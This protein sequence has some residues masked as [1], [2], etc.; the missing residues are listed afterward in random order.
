MTAVK[1]SEAAHVSAVIPGRLSVVGVAMVSPADGTMSEASS[2]SAACLAERACWRAFMGDTER[3]GGRTDSIS[4][5]RVSAE[6][7]A[8]SAVTSFAKRLSM[9]QNVVSARNGHGAHGGGRHGGQ[10]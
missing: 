3:G 5:C 7:I 6:R 10:C 2:N 4:L 8:E 1:A 9:E